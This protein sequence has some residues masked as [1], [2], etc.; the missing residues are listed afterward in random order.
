MKI[1]GI[2]SNNEVRI[3]ELEEHPFFIAALFQPKR[4]SLLNKHHPIIN[5]FVNTAALY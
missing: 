5:S 4:S 3:I 1:S 2:D